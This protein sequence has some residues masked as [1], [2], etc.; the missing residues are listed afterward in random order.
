MSDLIRHDVIPVLSGY[1]LLMAMLLLAGGRSPRR[2]LLR[3]GTAPYRYGAIRRRI[4][5]RGR[6][7]SPTDRPEAA[8]SAWPRLVRYLVATAA[9]GYMLFLAIVIVYYLALGGETSKFIRD[10]V[11]GGAWLAF[12]VAVP[13]LLAAAWFEDRVRS[14]RRGP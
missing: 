14:R 12:G 11:F 6:S 4:L 1:V 2:A 8:G 10:A 3:S 7:P 9:G 5:Q 13:A